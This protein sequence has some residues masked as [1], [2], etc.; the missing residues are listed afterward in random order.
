[1]KITRDEVIELLKAIDDAGVDEAELDLS[2]VE[3]FHSIDF[4]IYSN[5]MFIYT[6]LTLEEE[7]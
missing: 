4:D 2:D 1:M 3:R 7:K 5:G 6:A